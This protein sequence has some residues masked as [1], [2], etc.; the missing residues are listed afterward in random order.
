MDVSMCSQAQKRLSSRVRKEG[1]VSLSLGF[2]AVAHQY[3]EPSMCCLADFKSQ[4]ESQC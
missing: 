2:K 3:A 1:F 4:P